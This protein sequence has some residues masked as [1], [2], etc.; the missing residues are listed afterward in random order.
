VM[1]F[2]PVRSRDGS[3]VIE[4]ILFLATIYIKYDNKFKEI[5]F[6]IYRLK[7][8]VIDILYSNHLFLSQDLHYNLERLRTTFDPIRS[9]SVKI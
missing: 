9:E 4:I 3:L 2:V 7:K 5:F 8:I 1:Y 6:F